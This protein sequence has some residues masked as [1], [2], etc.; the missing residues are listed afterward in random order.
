MICKSK[1]PILSAL[2][3]I[4]VFASLSVR[5][6][7]A[8]TNQNNSGNST[9]TQVV[10]YTYPRICPKSPDFKVKANGK[11]VFV[12]QTSAEPFA[13][14][15]CSGPVD[16]E[17]EMPASL[18][19]TV[20][21]S[22]RKLGVATR[23]EGNKVFFK[24]DGP[25]KL[26]FEM[27]GMPKLFIY[28]NPLESN[29]PLSS[30]PNVKYFKTGQVYEVGE[31]VLKDNETLYVE[32]GAV[33]RGCI[34]STSAQNVRIAGFGV[35]DGSYYTK[36]VD[37]K[38]SIIF[39]DCKKSVI[40]DIIMIEPSGWMIVLG[41]CQDVTIR[42]V[43]QIGVISGS[44]GADIIGSKHIRIEN[45]MFRNGDDCVVIKSLDMSRH[46]GS[47]DYSKDVE[48]IEVNGCAFVSYRGGTAM[49]IGHEL[50]TPSVK[51][52]RFINCDILGIHDFGGVFG[53]HNADRA[54]VSD[55]LYENIRVEHHYNKLID[56]KVIKSMWGK[57]AERGQIR[58]VTFRNIDVTLTQFN[59]GYSMSLI[60]GYDAN[61]TAENI[62]FENFKVDG[63]VVT[64]ADELDLYCKQTKNITFK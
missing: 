17:V 34:R 26:A 28:A 43:K 53:I 16:I 11:E 18:S 54:T 37:S 39:E 20:S 32:G 8:Q 38:R 42:N 56:L 44:D 10:T 64:S 51:N 52:I 6:V 41:I 58:N 4:T 49:E 63:K 13:A 15:S 12:Y 33:I 40:E 35:L 22:P 47:F 1:Y 59:P 48:D 45:C 2:V 46:E 3:V 61:H 57:D 36:S 31:L 14:F 9:A 27:D 29:K 21:I 30:D 50:R 62:K 25:A 23:V 24:T 19:G 60:G 7:L 5:P 55:I